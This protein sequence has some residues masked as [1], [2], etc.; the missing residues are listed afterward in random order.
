MSAYQ[1]RGLYKIKP[2]LLLVILTV[3]KSVANTSKTFIGPFFLCSLSLNPDLEE[4]VLKF[5]AGCQS[6]SSATSDKRAEAS[7]ITKT[8]STFSFSRNWITLKEDRKQEATLKLEE[9]VVQRESKHEGTKD[10]AD[11]H[12]RSKWETFGNSSPP[13]S[14]FSDSW[15]LSSPVHSSFEWTSFSD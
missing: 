4:R 5:P 6:S 10:D 11:V 2:L 15:D 7:P 13:L 8:H 12:P 14:Y 3:L 1:K 9:V